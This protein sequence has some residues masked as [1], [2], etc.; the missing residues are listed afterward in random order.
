MHI[1]EFVRM[2]SPFALVVVTLVNTMCGRIALNLYHLRGGTM[3]VMVLVY[4]GAR[5]V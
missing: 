3:C 1:R 4:V 5:Q 2:L